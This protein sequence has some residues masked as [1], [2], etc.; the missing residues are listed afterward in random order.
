MQPESL[1]KVTVTLES[2]D[3]GRQEDRYFEKVYYTLASYQSPWTALERA[4]KKD[5]ERFIAVKIELVE[6]DLI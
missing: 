6:G 3:D 2:S 4:V 1:F 5:K